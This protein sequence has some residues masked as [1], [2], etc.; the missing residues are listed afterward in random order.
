[1][2]DLETRVRDAMAAAG[3]AVDD[4]VLEE[5]S[6]H[7]AAAYAA[8]RADGCD[9]T[10]AEQRV[11]LL[12][13]AW[14]ADG[15]ALRR[16]SRRAVA[17]VPP[18]AST[19]AWTGIAHDIVYAVRL[20]RRQ[21]AFTALSIV[22]MALGLGAATTL[23]SIADGVL[24]K[25]LPWPESERLV[26]ITESRQGH[27]PR[28]RGTISNAAY[29]AWYPNPATIEALGGWRTV[30]ATAIVDGAAVRVQTAAVT[31]SIFAVLRARPFRGRLFV[32]DDGRPGASF[33]SKDVMILSYGWWQEQFG[34]RDEIVGRA[35]PV[36][37][38]PLTIVGV[39]PPDFAF[40][41][42]Q[43][44]A[45]T[46]WA[47]PGVLGDAGVRRVAIFSALARLRP[48][49]TPAQASAEA[50]A[51]AR[52]GPDPGLA[53]VAMFGGNGP[54]DVTAIPAVEMMTA[55]V[56]PALLAL[57]AA[58]ALLLVTATANV[59]S[60]QLARATAR[61]RE[62]AIRAAIG[63]GGG[64][65]TRQLLIEAAL[66][67]IAGGVVGMALAAALHRLLPWA[68][69][70]D[71]PRAADVA[72]DGR[73]LLFAVAVSLAASIACGL[74][75]AWFARRVD[76]VGALADDGSAP[77]GAGLRSPTARA[78]TIIMAGQI[79]VSCV[80]LI[81][82]VLLTRSFV[83]LLHA[84]RG[85]DPR[86]VLTAR[87]SFPA[88][89]PLPRR[90]DL[91]DTLT[92]RAR[93]LPG[94]TEAAFGNAL[95]LL[96]S[97]GFRAFTMRTPANPSVEVSVDAMQRVVSPGYFAVLGLRV[98]A[99]RAF[100]ERDTLTSPSVVVVNRSFAAKY[101]GPSPIGAVIPN[102]GM[103]RGDND[104]WEVVGVVDD[105]RQGSV[106]DP[107]QPEIFMPIRQVGC[108]AAVNDA[109]VVVRTASD[110]LPYAARLRGL[111]REQAP[112]FAFDSM[113]TMEER[114]MSTLAKPR[115]YAVVLAA[116]G[117]FALT[118]AAV[119]VFGVLSYTV[120]QRVREIAV[121]TALGARPGDIVRLVLG[122]VAAVGVA[123]IAAGL[124]LALAASQWLSKVLYGVHPHD[125]LTFIVVPSV[126]AVVTV[127]ASLAPARRAARV[128]PIR[129]LK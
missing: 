89:E 92:A 16:R 75:P 13:A 84:D 71:F 34:G 69:P 108:A 31:P 60:L 27:A 33:P 126:L 43:T 67:G 76:L 14:C 104:R 37:G 3:H 106:A 44:R 5:L 47:V 80:L 118:I 53:A 115:L 120:A 77:V 41:D 8:A 48:G 22:T 40:P 63:A 54:A 61:R 36:D 35:I 81:G 73:V 62:M 21:R 23:F 100:Q 128:D 45:W 64:R 42:R 98:T 9:A 85:Y 123:G 38:R 68:L 112:S 93:A 111:L 129:A 95:P 20:A 99:G 122:Q 127:A 19:R 46:A 57:L 2:P 51:R 26:R 11:D 39:M 121:R 103:C 15:G 88:R 83:A 102:L 50:T 125:A 49:A 96:T 30:P 18:A 74:L 101:L 65:L 25:P 114:L 10:V 78:R 119:G 4:D 24:L 105:M 110:P 59:A 107:A 86:N 109:I 116:F 82:A 66:T 72:F 55:E 70:A 117:A 124:W 28:V 52:S 97:G 58:V 32:D 12:I 94:V 6:A 87:L 17:V 91:L 113:M 90:I 56:R 7:A 29:V 79:A 1:M